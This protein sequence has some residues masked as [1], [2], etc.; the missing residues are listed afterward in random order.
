MRYFILPPF[1]EHTAADFIEWCES[2]CT[3]NL[4]HGFGEYKQVL[5]GW[6]EVG[7]QTVDQRFCPSIDEGKARS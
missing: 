6:M 1:E 3:D 4:A 7:G 2:S 5:R